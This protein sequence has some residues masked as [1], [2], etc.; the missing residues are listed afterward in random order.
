MAKKGKKR[1]RKRVAKEDRKNLRLWAE[2]AREAILKPHL[3]KYQQAM[4]Q[5][6]R[7]ERKY[8]KGVCREFHA[9]IS[10]RT[11]DHEEPEISEN[12]VSS[13]TT[14]DVEVLSEE[15]EAAKSARVEELNARIRR[16]FTY[17]LRKLRKQKPSSGVDP[18]KDPYAVLLAK[19]SGVTAPPKARQAYQQFMHESYEEKIAPVVSEKWE[20]E[21]QSSSRLAELTKEPKAG[22]RA[23]VARQVFAQLSKDEQQAIGERAKR[24][25]ADAKAAALRLVKDASTRS[26]ISRAPIL[27]GIHQHTGLHVT[28]IVGG[29]IPEF[30]GDLRTVHLSYG[31]NLT[32]LAQHWPQWDKARFSEHVIKFLIEY[33][34]TAYTPQDCAKSALHDLSG[35]KYTI[36]PNANAENDSDSDSSSDSSSDES[37]EESDDDEEDDR[38]LKKRKI[39]GGGTKSAGKSEYLAFYPPFDSFTPKSGFTGANRDNLPSS[40]GPSTVSGTPSTSN[41]DNSENTPPSRSGYP[42]ITEAERQQNIRR[43]QAL[44]AALKA[45]VSQDLNSLM[46]ELRGTTAPMTQP[47]KAPRKSR[48]PA[49][50]AQ[51]RCKS[52]RLTNDATAPTVDSSVPPPIVTNPPPSPGPPAPPPSAPP[53]VPPAPNNSPDDDQTSGP[54]VNSSQ[55]GPSQSGPS[56]SGAVA[57]SPSVPAPDTLIPPLS[58]AARVLTQNSTAAPPTPVPSSTDYVACPPKAPDWFAD[59]RTVLTKQDLGVHYQAV[60]AAWT[61]MEEA[62]RFEHSPTNLPAKFRPKQ[63]GPWITRGRRTEFSV[64]DPIEYSAQWQA[65]WDSLQPA[66][67]KRGTDGCWEVENG[68]GEGGRE[69]G[70]LYQWGVNGVL[71]I[72]ASLYFWGRAVGDR[73]ELRRV[74]E[75]AVL[76]VVWMFEGMATY[77]EMFKGK[78]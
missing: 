40:A 59:A 51:V 72:V 11:Q 46:G 5:G 20:Q 26:L 31:R 12:W 15:E 10:W 45:D 27:Q 33:L 65:W 62:S 21:R 38:P 3:D 69:W 34:G 22:F 37:D 78:F 19:L 49:A 39:S 53:P 70:S 28:L 41:T 2:G 13:A 9:R 25:A 60:I 54:D 16:W 77:Y 17:R 63:L 44:L 68:Y 4:D 1:Q 23:E 71:T 6:R 75:S 66:W 43:N 30:G 35:A 57:S 24:E 7:Q 74:W 64:E 52:Q 73:A 76:D 55:S 47:P 8:L 56:Q 58:N 61:R 29:P 14:G 48:K 50:P 32:P 18:T 42:F 67:R 36:E